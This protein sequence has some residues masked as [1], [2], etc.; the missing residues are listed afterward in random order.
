MVSKVAKFAI[1]H[2]LPPHFLGSGWKGIFPGL[3]EY[4]IIYQGA[5]REIQGV[6][7]TG[8]PLKVHVMD[9]EMWQKLQEGDQNVPLYGLNPFELGA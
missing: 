3:W 7:L 2:F 5:N 1:V 8:T 9:E 4:N 6:F